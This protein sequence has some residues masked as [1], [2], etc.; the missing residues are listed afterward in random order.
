MLDGVSRHQ[1]NLPIIAHDKG[2]QIELSLYADC[3]R[4]GFGLGH[5]LTN[6]DPIAATFRQIDLSNSSP[7]VFAPH[8]FEE[9]SGV[10]KV[11]KSANLDA[12]DSHPFRPRCIA[13]HSE[14]D[15]ICPI[16]DHAEGSGTCQ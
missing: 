15:L 9:R 4:L 13:H 10:L 5:E 2:L 16:T 1:P 7:W 8:L 6:L 3:R 14:L 11:R 12:Q